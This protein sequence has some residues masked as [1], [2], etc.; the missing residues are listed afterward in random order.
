MDSSNPNYRHRTKR[1]EGWGEQRQHTLSGY[2]FSFMG[3]NSVS[4]GYSQSAPGF[5]LG[6]LLNNTGLQPFALK[7]PLDRL[8]C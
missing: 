5:Y 6:S 3:R 4:A 7:T 1:S 8:I 2:L